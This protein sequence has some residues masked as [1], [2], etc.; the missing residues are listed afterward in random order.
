MW[1]NAALKGNDASRRFVAELNQ[2]EDRLQTERA[3]TADLERQKSE[4]VEK[5][6]ALISALSLDWDVT[7][8]S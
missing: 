7:A 4:A 3:H 1:I 2:A 8:K 6:N 5:L